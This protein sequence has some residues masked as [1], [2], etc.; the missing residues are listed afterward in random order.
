MNLALPRGTGMG[1]NL[2][3]GNSNKE[4]EKAG[5]EKEATAKEQRNGRRGEE[6]PEFSP[7]EIKT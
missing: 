6:Q 4:R 3:R 7:S 2:S 5:S 1:L